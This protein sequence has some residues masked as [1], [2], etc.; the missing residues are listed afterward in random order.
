[1]VNKSYRRKTDMKKYGFKKFRNGWR[2]KIGGT[3]GKSFEVSLRYFNKYGFRLT[4]N[5]NTDRLI[6]LFGFNQMSWGA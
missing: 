3:S 1:M 2:I 6:K 5:F 4:I